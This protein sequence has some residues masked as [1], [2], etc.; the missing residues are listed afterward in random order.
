[1]SFVK[2][3][4]NGTALIAASG[5]GAK[6][7]AF[8]TVPIM[9]RLL[10]PGPYGEAALVGTT[11]SISTVAALLGIDMA[12]ARF[13]LQGDQVEKPSVERFCW[14]FAITSGA[15][16]ASVASAGWYF[17]GD[18]WLSTPGL[19]SA[20]V[21]VTIFSAVIMIMAKTRVRLM[22]SYGRIATAIFLAAV[23]SVFL[24]LLIA[25]SGKNDI[26]ALL[27]GIL[28]GNLAAIAYLGTPSI[29]AITSP[30]PLPPAKKQSLI[31]LGL[32]GSVTAPI[33]WLI[34]SMDRWFIG[35]F[36]DASDI[37]IYVMASNIAILGIML[38]SSLTLTWFPEASRDYKARGDGALQ[39]IAKMLPRLI[40]GLAI[41]WVAVAAA[42]GDILRL[43]A[44][45][46]FHSGAVI[47]PWLAGG[48]FFYGF[49]SL[50]NTQLF[51]IGKMSYAA[52]WWIAGGIISLLLNILLIPHLGI[53]GAAISQC[54][55]FML[56][57]LGVF[58][59]SQRLLYLPINYRSLS[60][61]LM[62][63]LSSGVLM[64]STWHQQPLISLAVKFPAGLAVALLIS[65][66]IAP[67]AV[68]MLLRYIR[69]QVFRK[70]T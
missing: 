46:P 3:V 63:A 27:P 38:N 65:L 49:A 29:S 47:I 62:L 41:V 39:D 20:Y 58:Y 68:G 70:K 10:G 23:V 53:T 51:L 69:S 45:K 5:I 67:D 4:A 9:S 43:L 16:S 14:R 42:G 18:S 7:L 54:L 6:L 8:I 2:R 61:V 31:S 25:L 37:G 36:R 66:V 60:L 17:F 13:Y 56:V 48:V 26:W 50:A 57:S 55:S 32:A 21:F 28:A 30:A 11:I 64:S 35:V 52:Y 59:T 15:L 12:Y 40:A 44:A 1:M 19:V 22:G 34:T 33:Y 24:N